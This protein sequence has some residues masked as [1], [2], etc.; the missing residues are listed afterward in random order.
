MADFEHGLTA[1]EF[2]L[3]LN[4][5]VVVCKRGGFN[6]YEYEDILLLYKKMQDIAKSRPDLFS[7]ESGA[8]ETDESEAAPEE[9]DDDEEK[10]SEDEIEEEVAEARADLAE[11]KKEADEHVEA[12]IA[13]LQEQID[14]LRSR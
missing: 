5:L 7:F 13:A 11:L 9:G 2:T 6:I 3:L 4:L 12:E 8:D 1:D 14:R 10:V